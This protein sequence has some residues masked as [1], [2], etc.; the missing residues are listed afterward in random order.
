MWLFFM[1]L[2]YYIM[3]FTIAVICSYWY[4]NIKGNALC[5]A[6]F[7]IFTKQFGSLVFAAMIV[8]IVTFLRMLAESG[9]K[10][11]KKN[12]AA[13]VCLC[14]VTC[15]LKCIEN[16]IKVINHFT[17]IMISVTGEDFISGAKSTM[18]FL[19]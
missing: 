7:W 4:Y 17:V 2:C 5:T 12:V 16:L 19:F 3:T 6:Y 13:A 10:G 15:L 8:A 18:G 14:L 1:F 11:N 9:R